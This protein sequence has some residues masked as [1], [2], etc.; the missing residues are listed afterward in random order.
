MWGEDDGVGIPTEYKKA[1]FKR[2]Y[3]RNTGF[4]LNLSQEILG[5]TELTISETGQPGLGARF[6]ILVPKGKFRKK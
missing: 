3:F 5:I 4:G 2:E 6:E 1:I